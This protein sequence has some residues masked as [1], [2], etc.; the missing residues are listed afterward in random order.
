MTI[1]PNGASAPS[2]WSNTSPPA[3]SNT[4]STFRPSFASSRRSF[5]PAGDASTATSAPSS[6][7]SARLSSVEA[8]AI[9]RPAPS[10][11]PSCTASDPTP[12]AAACTTTDSPGRSCAEVRYRCQAVRPWISSATAVASSTPSGMGNVSAAGAVAYSA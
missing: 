7:A 4:T 12:P 1:R 3:I 11:L 10:G 9:T 6:S 8:V 5:I 2:D